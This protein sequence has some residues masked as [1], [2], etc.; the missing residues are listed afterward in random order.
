MNIGASIICM[1]PL[2]MAEHIRLMEK[3][4]VE[5]LHVDIMDGNYV[6]RLGI[7]PEIVERIAEI[8]D[9]KLDVH[10]MVDD[11]ERLKTSPS[12]LKK[13]MAILFVS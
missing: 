1:D 7:Y 2:N 9:L 3:L 4:S 11:P 5:F 10:L 8:S 13:F 6:P 12:T